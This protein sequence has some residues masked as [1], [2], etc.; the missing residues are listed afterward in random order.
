M[1]VIRAKLNNR[2][3]QST[4]YVQYLR[5]RDFKGKYMVWLGITYKWYSLSLRCSKDLIK[6]RHISQIPL[7]FHGF[8]K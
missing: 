6:Q 5:E 3:F 4:K 8:L 2:I 1:S 7:P